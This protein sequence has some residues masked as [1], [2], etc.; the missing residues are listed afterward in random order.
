M[1]NHLKFLLSVAVALVAV[2]MHYF[3]GQIGQNFNKWLVLALAAFMII[4]VWMFPEP[5]NKKPNGG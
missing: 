3:Q 1:P 4:G 2:A 5:R